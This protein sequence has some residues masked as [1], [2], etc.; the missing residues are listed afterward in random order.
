MLAAVAQCE[1]TAALCPR[2]EEELLHNEHFVWQKFRLFI[3]EHIPEDFW[4]TPDELYPHNSAFPPISREQFKWCLHKIYEARSE[5]V[6]GGKPFPIYADFGTRERYG[7]RVLI[8]VQKLMGQ[9]RYLPLFCWFERLTHLVIVAFMLRAFAPEVARMHANAAEEK[10]SFLNAMAALPPNVQ[11]SLRTLTHW[12]A[13]FVGTSVVN[14][15]APNREWADSAET[16]AAL[17]ES[18]LVMG[19]GSG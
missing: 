15:H 13:R 4:D 7:H 2:I 3:T 1:A 6:H 14:P 9:P 11:A 12:T 17:V 16:V 8:E 5:Y 18:G 19:E 10:Q